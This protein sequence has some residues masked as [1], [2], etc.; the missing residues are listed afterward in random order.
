MLGFIAG[1]LALA[2]PTLF[3][4]SVLSFVI[5][6]LP[7]GDFL[8]TYAATLAS[9]GE[10]IYADQLD[11]LR[12]AYGLGEPFYVQYWKWISGIPRG[13]LGKSLWSREQ[14][15]TL[16]KR[17]A[18]HYSARCRRRYHRRQKCWYCWL[19]VL[20]PHRNLYA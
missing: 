3:G 16:I 19:E 8:T 4:I 20:Y 7:P 1:R 15:G 6:Q 2:I 12:Q 10:G 9:Q 5:M 18:D 11:Q 17:T 14:S 13:N